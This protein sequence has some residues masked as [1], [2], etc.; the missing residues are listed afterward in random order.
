MSATAGRVTGVIEETWHITYSHAIGKVA[1]HFFQRLRDEAALTARRCPKCTRALL[2]PRGYCDRC[3]VYTT[4]DVPVSDTGTLEAFTIVNQTFQ[5]LPEAPYC[6]GYVLLGGAD[7]SILNF[8]RGLDLNDIT[9]AAQLLMTKPAMRVQ[10][11]PVRHGAMADFW[12][13]VAHAPTT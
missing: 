3:F 5:G 12:F 2:P 13:E 9:A 7:T 8:I 6:F 1:T 11:A 10:Y 4:E